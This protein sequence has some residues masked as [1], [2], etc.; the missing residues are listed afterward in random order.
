M[1]AP[2]AKAGNAAGP[3]NPANA[4][5]GT[6]RGIPDSQISIQLWTFVWKIGW[7]NTDAATQARLEEV[8]RRLSEMGYRNVEPYSLNGLTAEQFD[9]LLEKYDLKA[10]SRHGDANEATWDQE[11]AISK[12]LGQH[13]TGSGGFAAPGIGS[14]EDVLATAE[15]LNRLGKRSVENGTGPIFGHNHQ[16]QFQTK[17]VDP[18]TGEL[19]S[20]WQIV[21]ENTDPRYVVFQ[22]DIL[23]AIIGGADPVELLERYGDRI[24]LLHVKDGINLDSPNPT[25]VPVGQGE[26]NFEPILEAAK[27]KVRYYVYEQDPPSP[28]DEPTFDPFA[29]ARAGIEYL[30]CVTS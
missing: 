15:R 6:G 26:V 5:C 27:G 20:A 3:A 7:W 30:D 1:A 9:A 28:F 12:T 23:W 14:Y 4:E 8:L 21:V 19:K 16:Y 24:A 25:Q 13:F 29:S 17:Y 22:V 2:P 10:P 11:L 18:E